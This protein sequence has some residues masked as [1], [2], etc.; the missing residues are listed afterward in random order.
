[1]TEQQIENRHQV[2]EALRNATTRAHDAA[3][4]L[5]EIFEMSAFSVVEHDLVKAIGDQLI[6]S[7]YLGRHVADLIDAETAKQQKDQV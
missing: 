2:S 6:A 7:F 4:H 1:M 3:K 5:K